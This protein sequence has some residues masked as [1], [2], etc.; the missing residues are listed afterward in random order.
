MRA[1]ETDGRVSAK[2]LN[3]N[4]KIRVL[5]RLMAEDEVREGVQVLIAAGVVDIRPP[6]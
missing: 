3:P 6:S 4:L 2:T 5:Q 1:A